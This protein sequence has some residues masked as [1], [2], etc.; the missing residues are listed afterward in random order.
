MSLSTDK[1]ASAALARRSFAGFAAHM[2]P[3]FISPPP[4]LKLIMDELEMV[5]RGEN[6]FLMINVPPR[7]A[8][9]TTCSELFP[10]YALAKNPRR[11]II[12]ACHSVDVAERSSRAARQ[13]VESEEWPFANVGLAP[14]STAA[15]RWHV[16]SGGLFGGR[17]VAPIGIPFRER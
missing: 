15:T 17:D 9:T 8:K 4:H 6:R 3:R 14:D 7:H 16:E 5:E 1:I 13:F 12:L 2:D 11:E 10:A